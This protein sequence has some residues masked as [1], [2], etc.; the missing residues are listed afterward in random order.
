MFETRPAVASQFDEELIGWLTTVSPKG[1]PQSSA[2][3]F[4]REGDDVVIYSQAGARK[5]ANIAA[6]PEVAFN[7]RGDV[8]G[9]EVV[10]IEA[11]ASIDESPIPAHQVPAYLAKYEAAIVRLGWTPPEFAADYPILIR[12]RIDRIRSWE[13]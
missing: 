10:S 2:V 8:D 4:L 6:H 13:D 5:L 11:T 9:D 7:L 3:W 12:L 1:R